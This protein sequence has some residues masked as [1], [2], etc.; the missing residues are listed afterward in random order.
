MFL[1]QVVDIVRCFSSGEAFNPEAG[2]GQIY[3]TNPDF[4]QAVQSF[5]ESGEGKRSPIIT[6]K[7]REIVQLNQRLALEVMDDP[8][9]IEDTLLEKCHKFLEIFE[10]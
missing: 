5:F 9:P 8:E 6:E 7:L 3:I 2:N 4:G 10:K 1:K